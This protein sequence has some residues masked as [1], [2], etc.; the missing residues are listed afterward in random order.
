MI[1]DCEAAVRVAGTLR[2]KYRY[3]LLP[4]VG[5]ATCFAL[6]CRFGLDI[7]CV[8]EQRH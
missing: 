7:N 6:A 2:A 5:D 1:G 4:V 3:L 8:P